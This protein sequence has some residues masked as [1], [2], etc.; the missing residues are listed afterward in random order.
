MAEIA[1]EQEFQKAKNDLILRRSMT[2]DPD[3]KAALAERMMAIARASKARGISAWVTN[4]EAT[5]RI[6]NEWR[7]APFY[8][9]P[10]CDGVSPALTIETG[11]IQAIFMMVTSGTSFWTWTSVREPTVDRDD[12]FQGPFDSLEE[13]ASSIIPMIAALYDKSGGQISRHERELRKRRLFFLLATCVLFIVT[14]SISGFSGYY[15]ARDP[16]FEKLKEHIYD[17]VALPRDDGYECYLTAA[18][19]DCVRAKQ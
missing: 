14:T 3:T 1:L 7:Q 15:S 17:D 12:V 6:Y 5:S 16:F 11:D 9:G 13:A 19:I 4:G 2:C 8:P 18:G 10:L